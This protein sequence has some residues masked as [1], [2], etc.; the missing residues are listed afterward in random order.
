[1]TERGW[2]FEYVM[3]LPLARV[4]GIDCAMRKRMGGKFGGPD[5]RDSDTIR[6]LRNEEN[7]E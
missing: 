6:N 7:A 1:L 2:T 4:F 5:Y 3:A